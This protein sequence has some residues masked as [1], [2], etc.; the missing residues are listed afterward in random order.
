MATP[1]HGQKTIRHYADG[2][3]YVA[4]GGKGGDPFHKAR[5]TLASEAR[6]SQS[7]SEIA[8]Q[9]PEVTMELCRAA[10]ASVLSSKQSI[11]S[12]RYAP[13]SWISAAE[14]ML[15]AVGGNGALSNEL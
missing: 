4:G 8:A 14:L 12:T 2:K 6:H 10:T 5:S 1:P 7:K 13:R 3:A 11:F 9:E 15:K